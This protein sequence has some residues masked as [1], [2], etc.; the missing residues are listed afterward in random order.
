[1]I[2]KVSF[3]YPKSVWFLG[4]RIN[5]FAWTCAT[6]TIKKTQTFRNWSEMKEVYN[7][8]ISFFISLPWYVLSGPKGTRNSHLNKLFARYILFLSC[9]W[10]SPKNFWDSLLPC[11]IKLQGLWQQEFRKQGTLMPWYTSLFALKKF[12][13]SILTLFYHRWVL[14]EIL[15]NDLFSY[16]YHH[17]RV[18][19]PSNSSAYLTDNIHQWT[20]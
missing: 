4:T 16:H 9:G 2:L 19:L 12:N 3:P 18:S 5:S 1:M 15:T 14:P 10:S 7:L 20:E 11:S 17:H 6:L 13:Q 8:F